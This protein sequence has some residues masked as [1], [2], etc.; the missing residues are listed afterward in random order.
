VDDSD[1]WLHMISGRSC[2]VIGQDLIPAPGI[3]VSTLTGGAAACGIS[4][5][6][7]LLLPL[8]ELMRMTHV[9]VSCASFMRIVHAHARQDQL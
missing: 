5:T 7:V 4:G 8:C 9:H 3:S 2:Q 6:D 1:F